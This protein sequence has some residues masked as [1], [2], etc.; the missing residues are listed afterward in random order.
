MALYRPN[1]FY[2]QKKEIMDRVAE[3]IQ[4]ILILEGL[5]VSSDGRANYHPPSRYNHEYR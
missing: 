1:E 3:P 5:F 4:M 2:I